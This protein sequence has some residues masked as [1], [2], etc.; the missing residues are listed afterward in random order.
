M[1]VALA[2]VVA[3]SMKAHQELPPL[4]VTA[5]LFGWWD[6]ADDSTFSYY[7][8]T[9]KTVT[10]WRDKTAT[11]WDFES[12]TSSWESMKPTRDVEVNGWSALRF[13]A[14]QGL[15]ASGIPGAT[16][17]NIT[18]FLVCIPDDGTA[19][20]AMPFHTGSSGSS[21]GGWALAYSHPAS[22]SVG[23]S[24][25]WTNEPPA[26]NIPVPGA[27]TVAR[28]QL[29]ANGKGRSWIDGIE[30]LP[31]RTDSAA[32]PGVKGN[33]Y[34]TGITCEI[35]HYERALDAA[36]I[37]LVEQYLRDKWMSGLPNTKNLT[38]WYDAADP[39]SIT[40]SL[41][42]VSEW[43]DKSGKG[44]H[45]TQPNATYQ[46]TT[47]AR[48]LGPLNAL[49]TTN[50]QHVITSFSQAQPL[51]Y[52]L[53]CQAD[54]ITSNRQPQS[55][56]TV[57]CNGGQWS[58]YAGANLDSGVPV[59][60][61]PHVVTAI[62]DR[63]LSEIHLDGVKI[64]GP[65]TDVWTSSFGGGNW[66]LSGQN[67]NN[68][69]GL[70][71]EWVLYAGHLTPTECRIVE[72][73]LM[74][75]WLWTPDSHPGLMAWYDASDAASITQV[76]GVVS[77]VADKSGS[78][79]HVVATGTAQP[80][81]GVFQLNGRNTLTFTTDDYLTYPTVSQITGPA[82]E[83]SVFAVLQPVANGGQIFSMDDVA[84]AR[85]AQPMTVSSDNFQ[86]V[87]FNM[88]GTPSYESVGKLKVDFLYQVSVVRSATS[89]EARLNRSTNGP[90][91]TIDANNK[92]VG[93]RIAAGNVAV[94]SAFWTGHLA[95]LLLYDRPLSDFQR[96]R[97][98][99]YL[100]TKWGTP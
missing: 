32:T 99:Q 1:P 54:L 76:G 28:V 44:W 51:T 19:K 92:P 94:P 96:R 47:G 90:T 84:S 83:W 8:P 37:E 41:G 40:H 17:R 16:A 65:S 57:Y 11:H 72:Q 91:T 25:A 12:V 35:L 23:L 82:G 33:M 85:V 100:Q 74:Q 61:N 7:N 13:A 15:A 52:F 21:Q 87:C 4:P 78:G 98:E 42:K 26:S 66:L 67:G 30:V 45:G 56:P 62:V 20:W 31:V 43:K 5:G 58:L 46:A 14:T 22:A 95:E 39:A 81:V 60:M 48:L 10:W 97:V 6:A 75:K 50:S 69:D 2:G 93:F 70:V 71:G 64:A 86:S 88:A 63:A 3:S 38:A 59:D 77:Q 80:S 29:D 55:Q 89:A 53:V 34:W 24:Y 18:E 68:W 27:P 9:T 79:R 73:H 36:E 49:D